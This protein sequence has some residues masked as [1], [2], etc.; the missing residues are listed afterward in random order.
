MLG[1]GLRWEV[2][3]QTPN[4]CL[5]LRPLQVQGF[6]TRPRARLLALTPRG[7]GTALLHLPSLQLVSSHRSCL[8]LLRRLL[9]L[10]GP[11]TSRW[12]GASF[13]PTPSPAGA[14]LTSLC[15]MPRPWGDAAGRRT[16]T[17][18]PREP[19][20]SRSRA[21]W[22]PRQQRLY[23]RELAPSQARFA[24][25]SGNT[26]HPAQPPREASCLP[27]NRLQGGCTDAGS[28]QALGGG[29]C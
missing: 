23:L 20:G 3:P 6:L 22:L 15:D 25:C 9:S 19:V 29:P 2:T 24:P 10:P 12:A 21:G 4:P 7:L 13:R 18:G 14:L 26:A 27:P 17:Q 16:G 5:P 1:E 11:A 28:G 8:V